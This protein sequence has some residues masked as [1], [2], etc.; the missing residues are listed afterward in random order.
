[1]TIMTEINNSKIKVQILVMERHFLYLPLYL[2][3]YECKEKGKQSFYGKLPSQYE[4]IVKPLDRKIKKSDAAVFGALMDS[5]IGSSDLMFAACDPTVILARPDKNALMAA[6]LISS[7]AFWAINHNAENV[8]VVSDLS[9]FDKII[10]YGEKTTSNLIARRIVKNNTEKLKEVNP[11][12]EIDYLNE[13][14]DGELVITPELL[15]IANL[16]HGTLGPGQKRCEIV[17]NLSS[18]KEFSNVL[19]TALFTRAEVVEQHPKLVAGV[20]TALQLALNAIKGQHE[21]VADCIQDN[22]RDAFFQDK[23]LEIARTSNVFP[24]T[25]EIRRDRW[26]RACEFYY[27]SHA[28]A[29]GRNKNT[30]NKKEELVGENVYEQAVLDRSLQ[31][32]VR[33]AIAHAFTERYDE[34]QNGNDEAATNT[35]V[36]YTLYTF[37]II[38]AAFAI[39][40][41]CAA[42]VPFTEKLVMACSWGALVLAQ[43]YFTR[44]FSSRI[45]GGFCQAEQVV[46]AISWWAAHELVIKHV[47]P[48]AHFIG[49]V[50]LS[51]TISYF[52]LSTTIAVTLAIFFYVLPKQS[53]LVDEKK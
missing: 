45:G 32:L 6:S 51:N 38:T 35:S 36:W 50:E 18:T 1:M 41:I 24:E 46:F 19:T 49:G 20:L 34:Q 39:G 44:T 37:V 3:E 10:C 30:L 52:L 42:N 2:A 15:T 14:R 12:G 26:L 25:I 8:R 28:I 31:R 16:L 13:L 4:V 27:I 7:S 22:Y 9:S 23:A 47:I 40:H 17:L 5:R 11:R 21:I 48:N 53:N 29:E 33:K 43:F